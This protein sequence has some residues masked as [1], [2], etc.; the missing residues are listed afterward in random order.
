MSVN[1]ADFNDPINLQVMWNRLIFIADQADIVLGCDFISLRAAQISQEPDHAASSIGPCLQRP[2]PQSVGAPRG[3]H[4]YTDALDN[5]PD[6][7]ETIV[8]RHP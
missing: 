1:A 7:V 2:G 8:I 5:S 3:E 6:A 4:A